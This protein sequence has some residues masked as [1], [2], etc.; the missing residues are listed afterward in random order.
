MTEEDEQGPTGQTSLSGV[1]DWLEVWVWVWFKLFFTVT[2]A[3]PPR[4]SL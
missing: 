4:T 3:F 1:P 2:S